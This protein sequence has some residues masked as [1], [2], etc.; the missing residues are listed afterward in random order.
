[1]LGVGLGRGSF[2]ELK[3]NEKANE[4]AGIGS[5]GEVLRV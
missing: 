2:A 5:K 1:M 4:F 3:Q